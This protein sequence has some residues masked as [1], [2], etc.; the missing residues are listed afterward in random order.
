LNK[1]GLKQVFIMERIDWLVGVEC[2]LSYPVRTM[3][4]NSLLLRLFNSE[5]FN[6]WIAVSY[7][8]RYPENIGIQ[9]Y[10]CNE[11]RKFPLSEIEFFLPQLW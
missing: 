1:F 7:L 9:H 3:S 4:S 2:C 10:L 6:C 5:F 8:F 11:L